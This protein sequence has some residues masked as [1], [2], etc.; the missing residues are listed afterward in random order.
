M[1]GRLKEAFE[2]TPSI[3]FKGI[4]VGG[5]ANGK[6]LSSDALKGKVVVLDF[7]ATWC[8]PCRK[9]MPMLDNL[10]RELGPKGLEV[11]GVTDEEEQ[12]VKNFIQKQP[13]SYTL[14]RDPERSIKRDYEVQSLPTLFVID[15]KGVIREVGIGTSHMGSLEATIRGLL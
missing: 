13:L 15:R 3:P 5:K 11:I 9:S 4:L 7:W 12:V 8:G 2:G 1:K 10:Q 14:L 6:E